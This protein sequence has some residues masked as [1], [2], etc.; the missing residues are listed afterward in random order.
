MTASAD[1]GQPAIRGTWLDADAAQRLHARAGA[2]RWG[3]TVDRFHETLARVASR[4]FTGAAPS[5]TRGREL[6]REPAPR[7]SRARPRLRRRARRRLGGLRRSPLARR[8]PRRA[9]DRRRRRWRGDRRRA[10]RRSVRA[11]RGRLGA[12]SA[13]RL[14]PRPQPARHVAARAGLAAPRRSPARDAAADDLRGRR[15]GGVAVVGSV[16][17]GSARPARRPCR[18]RARR[19]AGCAAAARSAAPG[20]LPR[21]RSDAGRGGAAPRRA[22]GDGVAQT[23]EDARSDQGGHRRRADDGAASRAGRAAGLLRAG[24]PARAL[25]HRQVEAG[26][27]PARLSARIRA[28]R[29][30]LARFLR[31]HVLRREMAHPDHDQVIGRLVGARLRGAADRRAVSGGA[32]EAHPDAEAW[33]AYVDGGLRADEVVRLETHLAGCPA[34]RR[35]LAVLAR[36]GV[37]RCRPGGAGGRGARCGARRRDPVSASSGVCLDGGRGRAPDGRDALVRVAPRRSAGLERGDVRAPAEA[38]APL[39][40]SAGR[41]R[42]RTPQP[43]RAR[44]SRGSKTAKAARSGGG[45]VPGGRGAQRGAAGAGQA[46][47]GLAERCA[48]PAPAGRVRRGRRE[49]G[50][51]GRRGAR[52]QRTAT[53]SCRPT[54]PRLRRGR[55]GRSRTSRPTSRQATSSRPAVP[56]A[57]A[58][59]LAKSPP[60]PLPAPPVPAVASA[61]PAPAPAPPGGARR[62]AGPSRCRGGRHARAA[63]ERAVDP[64]VAETV[65][66]TGR[67]PARAAR[68]RGPSRSGARLPAPSARARRGRRTKPPRS[69]PSATSR[70]HPRCRRSPSPAAGCGG[71]SRTAGASSRR[72]TAARRGPG[73]T[74]RA[75]RLRAG[76]APAI[77]SAWAVGERGLVLRFVGPRRLG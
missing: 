70:P 41:L 58:P 11:R 32:A 66:I 54:C 7:G 17:G 74:R 42:R 75:H 14:L 10:A 25:R 13:V 71:A 72:A 59:P 77:D 23:A 52:R 60:P 5:T 67:A 3:L 2:A 50:R 62:A 56:A 76:T 47:A 30:R 18:A 69:R 28:A 16:A 35:L 6:P 4:R 73:N 38:P 61:T 21:R 46:E 51:P 68:R 40:G 24:D 15:G 22:R 55:A 9:G 27:A 44:R 65:T 19:R 26:R 36:G 57:Q 31:S 64:Q 53:S 49:A 45:P 43:R 63:R 48:G 37:V 20:L 39:D 29:R 8:H 34:C 1:S 33:A 12:P